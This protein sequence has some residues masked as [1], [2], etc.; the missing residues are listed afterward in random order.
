[1]VGVTKNAHAFPKSPYLIHASAA[2]HLRV[3]GVCPARNRADQL[4]FTARWRGDNASLGG[5]D[6]EDLS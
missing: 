4:P 3:C 2:L 6:T 5:E 1:V